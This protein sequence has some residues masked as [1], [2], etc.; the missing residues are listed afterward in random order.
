MYN[1]LYQLEKYQEVLG[2]RE[3]LA[4][5]K[6][7][8]KFFILSPFLDFSLWKLKE[9]KKNGLYNCWD[10]EFLF[11]I[12]VIFWNFDRIVS[13]DRVMV[14][15]TRLCTCSCSQPLSV[16]SNEQLFFILRNA[17]AQMGQLYIYIHC[18][19]KFELSQIQNNTAHFIGRQHNI[20]EKP[21]F[22]DL[23]SHLSSA[24]SS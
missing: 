9:W 10:K 11:Y 21:E 8:K 23:S 13:V 24:T 1:Q 4:T 18:T 2:Y 6:W 22:W 7:G 5:Q 15:W 3:T 20:G 14:S 12:K 16:E 17:G 19:R